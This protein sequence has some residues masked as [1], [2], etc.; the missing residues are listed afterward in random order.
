MAREQCCNYDLNYYCGTE[1]YAD[2]MTKLYVNVPHYP[3]GH[4]IIIVVGKPNPK[5]FKPS[6]YEQ[7]YGKCVTKF[8]KTRDISLKS[9]NWAYEVQLYGL[10]MNKAC[11]KILKDI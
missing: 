3:E 6:N 9:I 10:D 2:V 7:F 1:Q 4:N 11:I 8:A 5:V